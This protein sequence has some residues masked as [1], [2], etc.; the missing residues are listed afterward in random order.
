MPATDTAAAVESAPATVKSTSAA[1]EAT[2]T[3]ESAAM[4]D[5]H[6]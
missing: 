4:E 3:M 5:T 1:V 6:P 2:S